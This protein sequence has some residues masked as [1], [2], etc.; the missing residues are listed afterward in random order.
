MPLMQMPA[1]GSLLPPLI[2]PQDVAHCI[3]DA[4]CLC[5][6]ERGGFPEANPC[7]PLRQQ[8]AC[9]EHAAFCTL[10]DSLI[11]KPR[12]RAVISGNR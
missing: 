5:A 3:E 10:R 2:R 11:F 7:E 4:A 12:V 9:S 6:G 1:D 8:E